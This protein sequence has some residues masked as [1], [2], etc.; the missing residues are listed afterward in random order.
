[1]QGLKRCCRLCQRSILPQRSRQQA[2][3]LTRRLAEAAIK[4]ASWMTPV[5]PSH[6]PTPGTDI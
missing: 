3:G 4:G 5:N 6:S 1:M 2:L